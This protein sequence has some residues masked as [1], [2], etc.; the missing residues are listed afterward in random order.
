[1]KRHETAAVLSVKAVTAA[2]R[3]AVSRVRNANVTGPRVLVHRV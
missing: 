2:A 1:M 3:E